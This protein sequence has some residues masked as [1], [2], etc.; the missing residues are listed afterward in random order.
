VEDAK[1]TIDPLVEDAKQTIDPL[2]EVQNK[3]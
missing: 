2:A 1:Q 3:K